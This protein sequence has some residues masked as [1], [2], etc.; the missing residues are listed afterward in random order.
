MN[1]KIAEVKK[2]LLFKE[3]Y[4]AVVFCTGL[5]LLMQSAIVSPDEP[6]YF[7]KNM[8]DFMGYVGYWMVAIL[9]VV[10]VSRIVPFENETG[11]D[12]LLKTYKY[13]KRKLLF[14]KLWLVLIYS[15][16]V[17]TFLY[18][19]VFIFF[20]SNYRINGVNSMLVEGN[21][22]SPWDFKGIGNWTNGQYFLF[23][24]IYMIIASF[25][26]ALFLFLISIL[27]K[28]SVVIMMICGG[29][30][31]VLELIKRFLLLYF[32]SSEIGYVLSL[33]YHYGYNG[34]LSAF[35]MV[36]LQIDELWK[37][38]VYLFV[39]IIGLV[40]MITYSYERRAKC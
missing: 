6:F 38:V 23:Q 40:S 3:I 36:N 11:I 13:G 20:S 39:P 26:F 10:G 35:Y 8:H 12:E 27:V 4:I 2:F 25:S 21:Y 24:Y 37:L 28:R 32:S 15:I 31:A 1:L 16:V 17:V 19:V 5:T 29:L 30:F 7:W 34:M 9:L 18:S 33:L 22:Q 14:A